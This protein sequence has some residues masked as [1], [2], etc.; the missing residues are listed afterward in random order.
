MCWPTRSDGTRTIPQISLTTSL[1]WF[2]MSLRLFYHFI[3]NTAKISCTSIASDLF[4][5][6][7]ALFLAAFRRPP[8]HPSPFR[9][10]N[11][12]LK[13][14]D[15]T[16]QHPLK[17]LARGALLARGNLHVTTV[18]TPPFP[19]R[20]SV[21]SLSSKIS[22]RYSAQLCAT[23]FHM[24]SFLFRVLSKISFTSAETPTG[25]DR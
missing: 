3:R 23:T 5:F 10:P 6:P 21:Q 4:V 12:L 24:F 22:C 19:S 2:L 18:A 17:I 14:L 7:F 25:Q 11:L 15:Y 9:S 8:H 16:P 1:S 13:R 20:T